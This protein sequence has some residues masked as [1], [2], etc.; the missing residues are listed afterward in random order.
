MEVGEDLPDH[1]GFVD[2]G[3]DPHCRAAGSA[4][5]HV[6]AKK[7]LQALR[8]HVLERPVPFGHRTVGLIAW[9]SALGR[10]QSFGI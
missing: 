5:L 1:L 7:P 8:P 2:A 4:G 6:D 9:P 3:D 10:T